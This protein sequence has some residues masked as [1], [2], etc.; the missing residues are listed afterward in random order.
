MSLLPIALV[1]FLIMDP[2]GSVASFYK[3]VSHLPRKRQLMIL[4]REMSIVLLLAYIF[5]F[6]GDVIFHF[7][8]ISETTA[9]VS[10]GLILFLVALGILFRGGSYIRGKIKEREEPFII[11]L[12]IPLIAGPGFLAT[13]MLYSNI[14]P[15]NGILLLAVLI[16]WIFCFF[17]LAATPELMRVLGVNGLLAVEKLMGMILIFLAVQRFLDGIKHF[18]THDITP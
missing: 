9:R 13:L 15:D 3:M 5:L 1:L 8:G 7:L 2:F 12:A 10:S 6:L 11:P 4:L 14:Q 18:M 17:V 16:S